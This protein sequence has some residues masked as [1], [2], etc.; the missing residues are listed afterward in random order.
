MN[1]IISNKEWLFSGAGIVLLSGIFFLFKKRKIMNNE[2]KKE[3]AKKAAEL[4]KDVAEDLIRPTS[5][6][7]G[8]NI[9]LFFDGV[10][11]WL[12]YVGQKEQIKQTKHLEDFKKKI[13]EKVMS[14]PQE[15]I[16]EPPVNVIGPIVD[17]SKY[18]YED[19]HYQEMFSDLLAAA[20]DKRLIR[21]I[22]PSFVEII[23]QLSPLDAKLLSMFRYYNT[24]PV[25][26]IQAIDKDGKITPFNQSLFDF[27]DK[28]DLFSM[29]ENNLLTSSLDNLIRLGVV[30][31]NRAIIELGYDYDSFKN[32]FMYKACD[33]AKEVPEDIMKIK[34][35]RIELTDFGRMFVR[36]VLP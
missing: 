12:A 23:K 10:T 36:V 5:K 26:D 32:N 29:D 21:A 20:C 13:N 16:M 8:K 7:I 15:S 11:G 2:L 27:K 9:G 24:Y 6:S 4:S 30:S 35:A 25:C 34:P 22:H 1:W 28:H 18:Y 33:M 17:A 19:I 14:I 31:K 3:F